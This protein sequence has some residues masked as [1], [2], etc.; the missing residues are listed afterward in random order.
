MAAYH[1]PPPT[2]LEIHD[3]QTSEKWKKFKAAWTN[4][5]L[6]LE[7]DGK[8]QAVQVATLLTVIGED[9]REVYSTFSNWDAE[10]DEAKLDPVLAKFEQYCRPRRN[11][12]FQRYCFNRR[13]QEAGE[14]YEQYRTTLR[15]MAQEC[16]FGTI[17]PDEILRDRLVF[18][19]RDDKVRERLLREPNLTLAKTDELCR[20]AESMQV[21]MKVVGD[22]DNTVVHAIK[23][24]KQQWPS[25]T[26]KPEASHKPT[27]DCWNCGRR[28]QFYKKDLCPAYGKRCNKCNKLNHFASQCRTSTVA[29]KDVKTIEDDVEEVFPAEVAPV[30]LD[31]SQMVTFQLESGCYLRFQVDTGAQCNV[32]PLRLY[33][34]ATKDNRLASIT[35][36]RSH[37]TAYGGTTLPVVGTVAIRVRRGSHQYNLHCKLVNSPNIRPLVGRQAC[38][39][40]GLVS[41]LDN[42]ELNKPDTGNLPVYSIDIKVAGS[43]DQLIK[44]YPEVFGSGIGRLEGEYH[45]QVDDSYQATQHAPRRVPVAIREQ[46][47]ETLTQLTKQDII[48][49]VTEPTPWISSMVVVPKRNGS[50]RICL[51]PKDLNRAIQRHHYPLPTIEDIATRLHGTKV[52]TVVDVKNGFWHVVLDEQSSYLTTFH[53]PF[54]RYRWKRMPFGICSAPEIFQRKM[55]EMIE[56]LQGVEV[57]AD[58]FLVFGRGESVEEANRDHDKNLDA[59]LQRCIEKGVRLNANKLQLRLTE[60]PFIGH[61]ATSEGLCVDPAKVQAIQEMPVPQSVPAVQRLLGLV[62]YLSKFLPHLADISQPLRIL[63]Q[64]DKD[65]VWEEAQQKAFE[66]LKTAISS[67]PVL[68]YYNIKDEVT[69]QC[70]ASQSGLGVALLQNEQPVAYAS[71]ALTSAETRYAQI[72]KELLAIVY[73]CDHFESY[74][75][76]REVVHV[77][78]DHKPLE[79]IMLKPLDSAPKRLQRMLLQLQKYNVKVKYKKG[80]YMYLADTL[81]R[82]HRSEVHACEFSHFLE[83]VDH[84]KPLALHKDH[85]QRIRQASASDPVMKSLRQVILDGWPP[86]KS[87]VPE[88]AQPYFSIRDELVLQEEL[89]L[90]GDRLVVP[91]A[92]RPE[93]MAMIHSTHIGVEGC[94]R[95]ARESLFWPRM[96]TELK[97]YISKCDVCLAHRA[98]P[99]KEPILQHVIPE[100]PWAKVG[101]DLCELNGR[102]LLVIVDYFSNFLEVDRVNKATTSGVT[103]V[104]KVMFSR[105][106]VPDQVISD[107]GPQFASSEFTTFAQQWGFEHVTSSPRYPQSN[108]KAE[109]AVK[110]VKMLFTKCQDSGQSEYLALLD[111]RNTPSEGMETSPAQHFFGRRCRTLLPST[112][113]LLSP[114]YPTQV[115]VKDIHRQKLKQQAYYNQHSKELQQLH[116]GEAVQ[117]KR[118]GETTWSSGEC[119]RLVGPRSYKVRVGSR[120]Y[121]R[122]RR[123]LIP[124][125]KPV[126]PNEVAE[127]PDQ[128]VTEDDG[129]TQPTETPSNEQS[130]PA[131]ASPPRGVTAPALRRSDRIHKAP[132]WMADY[133]PSSLIN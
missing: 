73:G 107:N 99:G 11:V 23:A 67:T 3:A 61:R 105:Y 46:L 106:G 112:E 41:Y 28:H 88:L 100:R 2:P 91:A 125:G 118:P 101:V 132:A 25:G 36:G 55:H 104:L 83:A 6:A 133:A 38:L 37:I 72:E 15:K 82:A 121:I 58:D 79:M 84:A 8:S 89:V 93:M 1:L 102:T 39:K 21:Q 26:S 90:K 128:K 18:G 57:I 22:G 50:L 108:G 13:Q 130:E 70:D 71:R 68:R 111:W 31:D 86:E 24:D 51:D 80:E 40:M 96:G 122:N 56:G 16:E 129:P 69:L 85:I 95:R 76:G 81:S 66:T 52:F 4:Y 97:E 123:Q 92:I 120:V 87:D 109:N 59:L 64:K 98:S 29:N 47:K 115:D 126:P 20:A 33:K 44:Q 114:R 27:R 12:P 54:G 113:S 53:T 63:T 116:P 119:I 32:L 42:D 10:G 74:V 48:Q 30:G 127:M 65:W 131:S 94:L 77:E 110:T 60:V 34:K 124:I 45:I 19:V 9:A 103:K 62:Q 75:Y 78:T 5:A 49:P 117:M 7:L 35:K 14:T 43:V 17:T